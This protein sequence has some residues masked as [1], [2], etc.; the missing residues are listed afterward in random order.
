M[1]DKPPPEPEATER[2][3][4]QRK[5]AIILEVLKGQISVPEA[6]RKY[7]FT[8]GEYRKWAD[9]Y[10]Q[11]GIE[12]LKT[13]R[14]DLEAKH[15]AEIKRLP[16]E[17]RPARDGRRNPSGGDA[18]FSFGRSNVERVV[19]KGKGPRQRVCRLLNVARST[20]YYQRRDRVAVVDDVLAK[21]MKHLIDAEP[22][23]GYRMV[24]ARLRKQGFAVNRK[25]VQRVMQI[26]GWQCHRRLKKRCS[27]RVESSVSVVRISNVRWATDA[28]YI[29]TRRDGL[30]FLNAPCV[31]MM[32]C[33]FPSNDKLTVGPQGADHVQRN[34][35]WFGES[36][37]EHADH[38]EGQAAA[39]FD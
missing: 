6:A 25:A 12:A 2:W 35:Q 16:C 33:R 36:F 15:Q 3:T 32:W 23:L 39:F 27:P 29:W 28:M 22:Y 4:A 20:S 1:S 24:W 34:E 31:R 14:K 37:A 30:I 7:G 19:A 21:R 8:Q 11:A 9:E 10:H 17:D 38:R 5:A 26:K 18:T 13:N